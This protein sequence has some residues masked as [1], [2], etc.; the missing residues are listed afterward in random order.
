[1]IIKN[2]KKETK[3]LYGKESYIANSCCCCHPRG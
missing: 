3:L 1:M 2:V